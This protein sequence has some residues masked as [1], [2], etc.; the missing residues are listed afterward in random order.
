MNFFFMDA[1]YPFSIIGFGHPE[2]AGSY[3]TFLLKDPKTGST[4]I[5]ATY[6]WIHYCV[7]FEKR[8]T[9]LL[10]V[11]VLQ[12]AIRGRVNNASPL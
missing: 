6:R 5:F 10:I 2:A 8:S 12:H 9:H 1:S 3:K 4:N 11:M 7:S